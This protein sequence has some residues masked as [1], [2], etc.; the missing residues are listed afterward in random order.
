[1]SKVLSDVNDQKIKNSLVVERKSTSSKPQ[2][3][4]PV[5][6][7]VEIL[8]HKQSLKEKKIEDSRKAKE[9]LMYRECT[10]RPNLDKTGNKTTKSATSINRSTISNPTAVV[11][12]LYEV[13]KGKYE[14]LT[15]MRED[16]LLK[17]EIKELQHCTF[18]PKTNEID[19]ID[20]LRQMYQ[21]ADLPRDYYK[22]VGR[23]RN[24]NEKNMEKKRKLE[25]VPVGENYEKLKNLP[26]M[27]PSCA[28]V[29]KKGRTRAPFMHFD[30]NIGPGK[31]GRLAICEGDDPA[32]KAKSFAAAFQL[33]PEVEENLK[34]LIEANLQEHLQGNKV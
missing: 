22:T 27:P 15:Q 19:R 8:Y 9:D 1:M 11:E 10:F 32:D 13:Q 7:R 2:N 23:M 20:E 26:F 16:Q 21:A 17:K 12:R 30:V 18:F 24:A 34:R 14:M 5:L 6:E 33:K 3:P 31:V 29:E 28:E 4:S 25:H